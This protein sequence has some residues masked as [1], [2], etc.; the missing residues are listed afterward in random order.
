M[1]RLKVIG[2]LTKIAIELGEYDIVKAQTIANFVVEF[3][4][5]IKIVEDVF[6]S[7]VC[8]VGPYKYAEWYVYYDWANNFKGTG[9]GVVIFKFEGICLEYSTRM[10]PNLE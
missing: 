9:I 2:T 3:S 5:F 6:L 7:N 8:N 10:D 4:D 1:K